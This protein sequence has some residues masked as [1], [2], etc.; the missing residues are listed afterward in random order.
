MGVTADRRVALQLHLPQHLN[1]GLLRG[2]AFAEDATAWLGYA[3]IQTT[4]QPSGHSN[5]HRIWQ[6]VTWSPRTGPISLLVRPRLEERFLSTGDDVGWRFRQFFK[7]TYPIGHQD[8][9]FLA[10]YD[11]VFFDLNDTDWGQHTG[12]S[13]NRLFAGLGW[14][15]D[16][17]GGAALEM[18]YLN[19]F[20]NKRSQDD[21]MN[22]ILSINLFLTF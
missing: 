8:R 7:A 14:R 21:R 15:L 12:F 6:Q 1:D 22:H 16:P 13:Q 18:G 11:E 10:A 3:W 17:D 5:E 9:L 20:I 19:Q 4:L 2:Y